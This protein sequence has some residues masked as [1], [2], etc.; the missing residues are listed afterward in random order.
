[1]GNEAWWEGRA[2]DFRDQRFPLVKTR[3]PRPERQPRARH[4][5]HLTDE[6][7]YSLK[8]AQGHRWTSTARRRIH[9]VQIQSPPNAASFSSA[10]EGVLRTE[11]GSLLRE[12]LQRGGGVPESQTHEG[13]GGDG[14]KPGLMRL[15]LGAFNLDVLKSFP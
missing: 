7:S 10:R 5:A 14:N 13:G 2:D 4:S 11:A 15:R 1:M 8:L 3:L 9:P 12:H 6:V